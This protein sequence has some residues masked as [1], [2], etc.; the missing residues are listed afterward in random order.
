MN[1]KPSPPA[2]PTIH[3]AREASTAPQAS[4]PGTTVKAGL[5]RAGAYVKDAV[6]KTRESMAGYRQGGIEQVSQNIVAYARSH[7]KTALLITTGVGL[8][9]GMLLTLGVSK[10]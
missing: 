8:L 7:P 2:T 5:E 9:V 3:V 1:D 6:D 10:K 4:G